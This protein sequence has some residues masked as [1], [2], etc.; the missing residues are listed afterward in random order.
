MLVLLKNTH[1]HEG[2][3]INMGLFHILYLTSKE[4]AQVLTLI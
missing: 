3:Q 2:F 1:L 4:E